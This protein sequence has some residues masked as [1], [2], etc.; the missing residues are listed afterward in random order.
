MKNSKMN[1]E[2]ESNIHSWCIPGVIARVKMFGVT[3]I[4]PGLAAATLMSP[5]TYLHD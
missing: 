4:S 3:I 5:E 1:S 2:I